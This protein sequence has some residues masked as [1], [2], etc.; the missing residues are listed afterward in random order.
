MIEVH[1]QNKN[2]KLIS[3]VGQRG[4]NLSH[5][6][7]AGSYGFPPPPSVFLQAK[8]EALC[9][10]HLTINSSFLDFQGA[11]GKARMIALMFKG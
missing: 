5:D 7:T 4:L 2:T 3:G 9:R 11:E 6:K 8:D 10:V 1:P